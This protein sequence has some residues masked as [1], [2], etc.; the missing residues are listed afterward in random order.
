MVSGRGTD[1]LQQL[2]HHPHVV[3]Q[4]NQRLPANLVL[5]RV[6]LAD[7]GHGVQDE[8]DETGHGWCCARRPAGAIHSKR[9][10]RPGTWPPEVVPGGEEI[11]LPAHG[12]ERGGFS[13]L[14]VRPDAED[15]TEPGR[16]G[17]GLEVESADV[18][19]TADHDDSQAGHLGDDL[20]LSVAVIGSGQGDGYD[21]DLC[22]ARHVEVLQPL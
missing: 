19:R 20:G 16:E 8:A 7:L 6:L 5:P 18:G 14:V 12:R 3:D 15:L 2:P 1:D 13:V 22:L 9:A 17:D 21:V 4:V 10:L 11:K